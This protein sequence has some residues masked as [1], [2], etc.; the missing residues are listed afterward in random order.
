M[1]RAIELHYE[2]GCYPELTGQKHINGAIL[3]LPENVFHEL[4]KS[5]YIYEIEESTLN[6]YTKG[7]KIHSIDCPVFALRCMV[8]FDIMA[9]CD[10]HG[11]SPNLLKITDSENANIDFELGEIAL[12]KIGAVFKQNENMKDLEQKLLNLMEGFVDG[13]AVEISDSLRPVFKL[14]SQHYLEI[15][16][17]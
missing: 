17:A 4:G 16:N 14:I 10:N 15:I 1:K 7:K 8:V 6:V 9:R 5:E 11:L 12:H 13:K 2:Y 3:K